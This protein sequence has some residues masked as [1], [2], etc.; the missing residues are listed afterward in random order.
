MSQNNRRYDK[1][2]DAHLLLQLRPSWASSS[3]LLYLYLLL[4]VPISFHAAD[5]PQQQRQ[6][7]Q[8][9]LALLPCGH[10]PPGVRG[11]GDSPRSFFFFLL[12]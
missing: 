8:I 10:H 5:T 4:C 1:T 12:F 11:S 7:G 9:E 3:T 2:Q 6:S